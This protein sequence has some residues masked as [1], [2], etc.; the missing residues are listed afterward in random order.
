MSRGGDGL[1]V[2]VNG[3]S[4]GLWPC[5]LY[6]TN[7]ASLTTKCLTMPGVCTVPD[8]SP[9]PSD[10]QQLSLILPG[11]LMTQ[12]KSTLLIQYRRHRLQYNVG[13]SQTRDLKPSYNTEI[14]YSHERHNAS[15]DS[16]EAYNKGSRWLSN[17]YR[18]LQQQMGC[19]I[20]SAL[21]LICCFPYVNRSLGGRRRKRTWPAFFA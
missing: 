5:L 18:P 20:K 13:Y 17:Q 10:L 7:D 4:K 16:H 3:T 11:Q 21:H 12:V 2:V 1:A 9:R 14:S 8:P 19:S 6:E 15:T